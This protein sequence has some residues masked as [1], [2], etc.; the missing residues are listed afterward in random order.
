MFFGNRA[1]QNKVLFCGSKF[2]FSQSQTGSDVAY[3]FSGPKNSIVMWTNRIQSKILNQAL[4]Q[5]IKSNN[6][7]QNLNPP[8]LKIDI[9]N[10]SFSSD[11]SF[12]PN[13][14]SSGFLISV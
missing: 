6:L 1:W 2:S 3:N 10:K 13:K 12:I 5:D 7:P 9:V 14:G 4:N 8:Y 11:R